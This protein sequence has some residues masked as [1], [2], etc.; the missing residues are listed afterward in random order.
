MM[1]HSIMKSQERRAMAVNLQW[2]YHLSNDLNKS[3]KKEQWKR[4]VFFL[5]DE[6]ER[7]EKWRLKSILK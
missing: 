2:S 1:V 4:K 3:F 7:E 6:M 5:W